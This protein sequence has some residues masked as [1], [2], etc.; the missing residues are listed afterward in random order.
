MLRGAGIAATA[1]AVA[2]CAGA[3]GGAAACIAA[4]VVPAPLGI[5]AER[6]TAPALERT[7]DPKIAAEW[8]GEGGAEHE[9]APPAPQASHPAPT[10]VRHD[11][12]PA[13]APAPEP[14]PVEAS[15]AVEY[16]PEPEPTAVAE[17]AGES[18]PAASSAGS[19]AGEFGP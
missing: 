1:K 14:E 16:A 7:I 6:A 13:P 9:T 4:G 2:I 3:A 8:S 11:P 17:P 19:P 10:P 18:T 12:P 5:G 15:D